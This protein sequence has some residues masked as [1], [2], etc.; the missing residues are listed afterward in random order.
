[1]LSNSRA[2]PL[3]S[4]GCVKTIAKY[5]PASKWDSLGVGREESGLG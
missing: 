4:P 1:M 3:S 5:Q 2:L